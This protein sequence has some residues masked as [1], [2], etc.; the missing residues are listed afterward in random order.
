LPRI[1]VDF[2]VNHN[3]NSFF[4][5]RN[6]AFFVFAT[7]Q[8]NRLFAVVFILVLEFPAAIRPFL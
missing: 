2:L 7:T 6:D 1:V 3:L 5:L 4:E 8:G